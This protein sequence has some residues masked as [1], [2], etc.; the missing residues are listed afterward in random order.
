MNLDGKTKA[1]IDELRELAAKAFEDGRLVVHGGTIVYGQLDDVRRDAKQW[2]EEELPYPKATRPRSAVGCRSWQVGPDGRLHILSRA[3]PGTE[4]AMASVDGKPIECADV[5][6]IASLLTGQELRT[7]AD[8]PC[9]P[10][11]TVDAE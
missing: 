8:G 3:Y 10:T 1:E 6:A 11:E 2:A 7:I 9:G 5:R 4:W